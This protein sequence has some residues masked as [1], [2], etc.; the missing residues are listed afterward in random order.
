M[1]R[2]GFDVIRGYIF[3][4]E[5]MA[6]SGG[7]QLLGMPTFG[8]YAVGYHVVQAFLGRTGMS[9]AD[10]TFIPAEEIVQRSMVFG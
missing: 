10:A 9:V 2:T 7:G 3:G 8:G 4:D 5:V 1:Q 6:R